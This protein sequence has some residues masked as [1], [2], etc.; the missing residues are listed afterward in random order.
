MLTNCCLI[1]LDK[2][3][4]YFQI[5]PLPFWKPNLTIAQDF[6]ATK[7]AVSYYLQMH[8]SYNNNDGDKMVCQVKQVFMGIHEYEFS[9]PSCNAWKI[10]SSQIIEWTLVLVAKRKINQFGEENYYITMHLESQLTQ[11]PPNSHSKAMNVTTG[12]MW[13]RWLMALI[14]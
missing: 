3:I 10:A 6:I 14:Y 2:D 12:R 8:T 13:I 4:I 5:S 1:L 11:F 9:L 7:Y